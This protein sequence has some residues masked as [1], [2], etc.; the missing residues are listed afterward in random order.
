[1]QGAFPN[2]C[3]HPSR[4]PI[5]ILTTAPST[6]PLL[7]PKPSPTGNLWPRSSTTRFSSPTPRASRWR[8]SATKPSAIAL[9]APWS[10]RSGLPPRS[11]ARRHRHSR[12]RDHRLSARRLAGLHAA[13]GGRGADP[14]GRARTR[15]GAPHRPA[16][17]RQPPGRPAHHSRRRQSPTITAPCSK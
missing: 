8:T 3:N 15:H 17:E 10:I 12:R 7:P 5:W 6:R 13:P 4:N 14:P 16:Q 11:P 2:G 9:P 1:M